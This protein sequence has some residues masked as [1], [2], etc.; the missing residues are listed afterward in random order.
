MTH[1]FN[2][3]VA[4]K[5]AV[6]ERLLRVTRHRGFRLQSLNVKSMG[7]EF[8]IQLSVDSEKP[9]IQLVNQLDKLYDVIT[10]EQQ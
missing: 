1:T 3:T 5:P 10:I 7:D 8:S 6:L 9:A 2:V 4:D